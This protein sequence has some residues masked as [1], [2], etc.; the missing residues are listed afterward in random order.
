[1]DNYFAEQINIWKGMPRNNAE[2][3]TSADDFYDQRLMPLARDTFLSKPEN[4]IATK[5]YGMVLTLG[6][7]WQ[8]L[9]LSISVLKPQRILFLG[10]DSVRGQLDKLVEFLNLPPERY[11]FVEVDR[12]SVNKIYEAI[13]TQ[14]LTWQGK[15]K[16]ALDITGGT[17]AMVASA[18]MMG[19]MLDLDIY[20]VESKY[21]P[22]YRRPEPGSEYLKRL[23][24]PK[25]Y[26]AKEGR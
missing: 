18:A 23:I 9:A 5:Y 8:P 21:L 3:L 14:C 15:G 2:E 22:L 1:M 6:T 24:T 19:A 16:V 10:T 12:S 17:K 13:H 11:I 26:L 4:E 7:S 25:A 20:Y